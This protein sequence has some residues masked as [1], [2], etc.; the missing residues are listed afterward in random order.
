MTT[1]ETDLAQ[2]EEKCPKCQQVLE[3]VEGTDVVH[4]DACG[5]TGG[6]VVA[7]PGQPVYPSDVVQPDEVTP[8]AVEERT[9]RP[10]EAALVAATESLLTNPG[11]PG[12]ADFEALAASALMIHRSGGAPKAIRM[13]PYLA[14][15]VA[16][17]GR[18]LGISPSA[19]MQMIDVIGDP[20]KHPDDL[21]LSISPELMVA[22]VHRLKLGKVQILSVDYDKGVAIALRPDGYVEKDLEGNVTAI[23]GELGRST[24]TW[25]DAIIAGLVDDRCLNARTHWKKPGTR[26]TSYDDRCRCRQGWRTYPKRML[27]WRAE[28]FAC[29]DWFPEAGVGLYSAEEL[30][31]AVDENGRAIDPTTVE[32]PPGYENTASVPAD[33]PSVEPAA[34]E[35]IA[36]IKARVRNLPE[37]ERKT[38]LERWQEKVNEGRLGPVDRL[39]VRQH[40]IAKALLN[41]AEALARSHD[42]EWRALTEE[43]LAAAVAPAGTPDAPP[44]PETGEAAPEEAEGDAAPEERQE[45]PEA[46]DPVEIGEATRPTL[47]EDPGPPVEVD[48]GPPV[49]PYTDESLEQAIAAVS[50]MTPRA[51]NASL[52]ERGLK[53]DGVEE[54]VRRQNLCVAMATEATQ[55]AASG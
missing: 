12:R 9:P 3:R 54:N 1:T 27:G 13:D 24:F 41:G 20:V 37:A 8:A 52:R 19:A 43:E 28:G 49:K 39:T 18:D 6:E 47:L 17:I 35:D 11:A 5:Y 50:I 14:F 25:E 40:N 15:H 46:T 48:P 23:H 10:G 22:Q 16:M 29:A 33:D 51:L 32:L 2:G 36:S 38:F 34:P 4:C 31:A 21:Q 42:K 45:A 55:A 53:V 7:D 30:G 26:G 44:A